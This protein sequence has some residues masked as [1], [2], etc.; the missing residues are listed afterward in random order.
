MVTA[1]GREIRRCGKFKKSKKIFF[2]VS[3]LVFNN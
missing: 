2:F 3:P 1:W